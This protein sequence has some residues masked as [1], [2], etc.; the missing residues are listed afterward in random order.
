MILIKDLVYV[1]YVIM[2]ETKVKYLFDKIEFCI[3]NKYFNLNLIN[4]LVWL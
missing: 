4:Y 3:I 2:V 1:Y